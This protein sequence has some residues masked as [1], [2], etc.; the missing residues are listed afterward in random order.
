MLAAPLPCSMIA[1]LNPK[2]YDISGRQVLSLSRRLR[3][4]FPATA[5][6][7]RYVSR[8]VSHP[9][10][11]LEDVRR[12]LVSCRY[13]SDPE[14]FGKE[15]HWMPP[16]EFEQKRTGDCEDFALWTWR[17]LL[18]MGYEAR[19]A[20][21]RAGFYG[22]G[23]AWVTFSDGERHYLLEPLAAWVGSALPR[24]SILRYKPAISVSW[25]GEKIR[26]FAHEEQH[27]DP[28]FRELPELVLE[29]ARFW[30]RF[31]AKQLVHL[32]S[33]LR[34]AVRRLRDQ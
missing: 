31:W 21:G 32:P 15:E 34:R 8:P 23:H 18:L 4:Q 19:F 22:E 6:M 27:Y 12:F 28:S 2:A 20:G 10:E 16:E 30:M 3:R 7:G 5:P 9:C 14:Q 33:R 11:D 29:W 17:Q 25:D 24:L 1:E 13:V 26:Y